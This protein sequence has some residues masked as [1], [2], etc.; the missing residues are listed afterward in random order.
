MVV[1]EAI[2]TLGDDGNRNLVARLLGIAPGQIACGRVQR[3]PHA[4]RASEHNG[5]REQPPLVDHRAAGHLAVAVQR[6]DA[7]VEPLS[8]GVAVVRPD[9]RRAS[10]HIVAANKRRMPNAH[11]WHIGQAIRWPDRQCADSNAKIAQSL[12]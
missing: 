6:E 3:H 11:P 5:R 2:V 7:R 10:S 1:Q 12:C 9:R 8:H 4:R